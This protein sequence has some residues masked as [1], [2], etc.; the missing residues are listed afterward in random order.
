MNWCI[1]APCIKRK[2]E[3]KRGGGDV[4]F[5]GSCWLVTVGGVGGRGGGVVH[6]E[7]ATAGNWMATG[8]PLEL[9]R[10]GRLEWFA[11]TLN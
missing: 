3:K 1:D 11:L 2:R 9:S 4:G 7:L 6:G 10:G 8:R 5:G